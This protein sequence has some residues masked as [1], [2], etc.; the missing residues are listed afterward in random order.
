M[1]KKNLILVGALVIILF[2]FRPALA[3]PIFY[4]VCVDPGHGGPLATKYGNM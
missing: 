1:S 4:D 2:I 3:D